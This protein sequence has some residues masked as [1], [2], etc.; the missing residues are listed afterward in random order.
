MGLVLSLF[1]S[2]WAESSG[3]M[4]GFIKLGLLYLE[5]VGTIPSLGFR[6]F[7]HLVLWFF[8]LG[9]VFSFSV[10]VNFIITFDYGVVFD[11]RI[12]R[13]HS[14]SCWGSA[15]FLFFWLRAQEF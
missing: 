10:V 7:T 5:D 15:L 1:V 9:F 8:V 2:G 4:P 14:L 3:N 11:E 6:N 13:F 12:A